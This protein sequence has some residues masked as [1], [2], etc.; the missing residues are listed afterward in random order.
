MSILE[1]KIQSKKS[2]L[3]RKGELKR[4]LCVEFRKGKIVETGSG[5]RLRPNNRI[6]G[7]GDE[8]YCLELQYGQL[9]KKLIQ[10]LEASGYD[11]PDRLIYSLM[12][13]LDV[14]V[15]MYL[16]TL[17][18]NSIHA[19]KNGEGFCYCTPQLY[20]IHGNDFKMK[21]DIKTARYKFERPHLIHMYYAM[22]LMSM[23]KIYTWMFKR[24]V[25]F[26]SFVFIGGARTIVGKGAKELIEK[27]SKEL[28]KK[29][30]ALIE[31]KV[32]TYILGVSSSI[33][34][35]AFENTLT[36]YANKRIIPDEV[37]QYMKKNN[38][39]AFDKPALKALD[40]FTSV[41]DECFIKIF[42]NIYLK[43]IEH[44]LIKSAM[45]SGESL[46]KFNR[47]IWSRIMI[48]GHPEGERIPEFF[49]SIL[50]MPLE[51]SSKCAKD[52]FVEYIKKVNGDKSKI[53]I[54][55]EKYSKIWRTDTRA[56]MKEIH[57][58]TS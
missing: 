15:P 21:I 40:V 58:I 51:L 27:S 57:N 55:Q 28:L 4:P 5:G 53:S 49:K 30:L 18:I 19:T 39:M 16:V 3:V 47:I 31:K 48:S 52:L 35:K 45:Y 54:V 17:K 36:T 37:R 22:G 34:K 50:I 33:I 24:Q 20:V 46:S 43:R 7:V 32:V 44:K 2:S 11:G 10:R 1:K 8:I 26:A 9:T 6:H 29:L 14:D 38:Y 13:A 42:E 56:R 25:E 23:M 41:F 12:Y